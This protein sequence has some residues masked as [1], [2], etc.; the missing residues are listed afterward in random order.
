MIDRRRLRYLAAAFL[1]IIVCTPGKLRAQSAQTQTDS[2]NVPTFDVASIRPSAADTIPSHISNPIHNAEFNAVNVTVRDLLEVA[3]ALPETQMLGGPDWAATERFDIKATAEPA[4]TEQL[5]ALPAD[6]AK[7]LKRRMLQALLANRFRVSTH[8]ENRDMPAFA[9]IIAKG[10]SKLERTTSTA[11]DLSGERGRISIKGGND[12]LTV[13]AFELSWRLGRP[14]INRTGL[15]GRYEITL[16]WAADDDASAAGPEIANAPSLFTAIQEQLG[17]KLE[18]G[19][20]P[21]P[22]LIIDHAEKPSEN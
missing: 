13:L 6:Q 7:L 2:P 14:V 15:Q 18:S 9:L 4:M 8:I 10:G 22:T 5:T 19:R 20:E 1:G 17:L 21:V 11:T 12:S 3:F 16:T